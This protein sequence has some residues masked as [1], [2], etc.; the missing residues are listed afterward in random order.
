MDGELTIVRERRKKKIA[1]ACCEVEECE[2]RLSHSACI[3]G[4]RKHAGIRAIR[5]AGGYISSSIALFKASGPGRVTE[6]D[7]VAKGASTMF[8]IS[9]KFGA[10]VLT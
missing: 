6:S 8:S 9:M 7:S 2:R 1:E 4:S 10:F 3:Q 5:E